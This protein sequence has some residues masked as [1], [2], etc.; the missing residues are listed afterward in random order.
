MSHHLA[1]LLEQGIREVRHGR[2]T[3]EEFLARHPAEAETLA[4]LLRLASH[5]DARAAPA[6]APQSRARIT[7]RVRAGIEPSAATRQ[8]LARYRPWLVAAA[9]AA[10]AFTGLGGSGLA[11]RTALPGDPLYGVKRGMERLEPVLRREDA[12]D[13]HIRL[14]ERRL[15]EVQALAHRRDHQRLPTALAAYEQEYLRLLQAAAT[16]PPQPAERAVRHAAAQ[17]AALAALRG[18]DDDPTLA[19]L[20]DRLGELTAGLAA[21]PTDVERQSAARAAGRRRA[22]AG[23][24][25][26]PAQRGAGGGAGR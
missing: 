15:G 24:R 25:R 8:A 6:P 5:I 1:E 11:A 10:V 14:S 7:A 16:A 3:P 18:Q 17:I 20:V 9:I 19:A 22:P 2:T 13:R 26:G 4:P 21:V 23:H 12:V